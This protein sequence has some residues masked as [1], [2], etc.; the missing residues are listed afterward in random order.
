MAGY[1]YRPDG[2]L[3]AQTDGSGA[4]AASFGYDDAG[5]L[6]LV[7]RGSARYQV[8]TD[9]LGSPLLIID[10]ST[11]AVAEAITYD[12]WGQVT[13]DTNP[14]FIP[15]GFAGGLRDVDTGLVKFGAR[16]Y[17][18]RTGRWTGLDPIQYAGG[19]SVLYRYVAG[20]PVNRTD[21]SGLF[22]VIGIPPIGGHVPR[23]GDGRGAIPAPPPQ[24]EGGF[25][26]PGGEP[27]DSGLRGLGPGGLAGIQRP[28][29][30]APPSYPP[31]TRGCLSPKGCADFAAGKCLLLCG[32]SDPHDRTGD[33]L[34]F[35]F[36]AAGEFLIAASS[37]ARVVVQARHEPVGS[38]TLVTNITAVAAS[39]AG[40]RIAVYAS[41]KVAIT[42]GGNSQTRS[43]LSVRLPH[44][45]IVER[46]G[47]QVTITWPGGSRLDVS[48]A[49]SHL[50]FSFDPDAATAPTLRGLLGSADGNP[51]NDFTARDGTVLD[52]KDPAFATKVYDPF[53]AS[54]RITQSE[55]LFDYGPGQS[56]A[57]FTKPEIPTAPATI[58]ALDATAR[59]KAEAL[60]SV[61][62][63]TLEPTR[64]NCIL[65]V[66]I[67]GDSS[68]AASAAAVQV[69]T[70]TAAAQPPGPSAG[71]FSGMDQK[72]SGTI[73]KA[74]QVD[75]TT[76][77]AKAGDVVYLRAQGVCVPG[78]QWQL[79]GPSGKDLGLDYLCRDLGRFVLPDAGTYTVEVNWD[80]TTTGA[81]A[82]EIIGAPVERT[83]AYL[84]GQV[85]S[86]RT[87]RI[88]EWHRY[89]FTAKAGDAIFL[90]A[91]GAYVAGLLWSLVGPSGRIALATSSTDLDRVVL[92]ST[93]AYAIEVYADGTAT[94]AYAFQVRAGP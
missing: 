43:D 38:S 4:V 78:L 79:V 56:T 88:G 66:G 3:A 50:D 47:A 18:P 73:S 9:H 75:K 40:D 22:P 60:C 31:W 21:P 92:P 34:P 84:V 13:S 76:F 48:R 71:S 49:G 81:Y 28:K 68:Y 61:M 86:D 1:L 94:G 12:A 55:S 24:G 16:E 51:A 20:D 11:G 44:G 46:H 8:V 62:G 29:P 32:N 64:T 19:D 37:D 36:Q 90:D 33:G 77:T 45:G 69:A 27:Q 65:D 39:V 93:G 52:Q 30:P 72:I 91:Q 25:Q 14:G 6:T 87:T 42:I 35:D 10:A 58:G 23:P 74:S 41:D 59:S 2:A 82:F 53:G 67:T 57:T 70:V 89:T 7:E 26:P 83:T 80:Q 54:W 15:V 63:V 17:D 5:R 85:I